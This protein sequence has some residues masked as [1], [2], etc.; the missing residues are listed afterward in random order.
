MP[1]TFSDRM[2]AR[3][4]AD[5]R[6]VQRQSNH[7][8]PALIKALETVADDQEKRYSV[9]DLH[10]LIQRMYAV[11]DI[12][13]AAEAL[14]EKTVAD[15][16]SG[17]TRDTESIKQEERFQWKQ[18]ARANEMAIAIQMVRELLTGSDWTPP[19]PRS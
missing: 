17:S 11:Q 16:R 10:L 4:A 8:M 7:N 1:D 2:D 3:T 5:K 13:L 18:A 9:A 19:I 15:L 14:H 6:A 12:H